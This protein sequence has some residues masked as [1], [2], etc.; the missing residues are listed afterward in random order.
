MKAE[1]YKK[2]MKDNWP[3]PPGERTA[4]R[5]E[6]ENVLAGKTNFKYFKFLSV[7]QC[8][9][10]L[11]SGWTQRCSCTPDSDQQVVIGP[12]QRI[13]DLK[14]ELKLTETNHL[15][16]VVLSRFHTGKMDGVFFLFVCFFGWKHKKIIVKL[17]VTSIWSS[18]RSK[19]NLLRWN[20][21]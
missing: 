16:R 9:G 15:I 20:Q 7:K 18:E 10:H 4:K 21:N 17:P 12:L 13:T 2:K 19:T 5:E 3:R 14:P 8:W 6:K 11:P 1:L